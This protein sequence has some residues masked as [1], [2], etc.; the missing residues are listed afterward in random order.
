MN[1]RRWC[2]GA[3][4][5]GAS[6]AGCVGAGDAGRDVVR[7]R[8]LV[9]A[10]LPPATEARVDEAVFGAAFERGPGLTLLLHPR[11]LPRTAADTGASPVP[12][13]LAAALRE[14]GVVRGSCEPPP[15][16]RD[17]PRC[18]AAAA[19][20]VVRVSDPFRV[21]GDT[22]QVYLAA[23]RF[24]PLTGP[25]P[26]ALRLEKVYQLVEARGRWRVVGEARDPAGA[27]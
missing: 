15:D 9:V 25:K 5:V 22:L 26:E 12:A 4:L 24:A 8:G 16:E 11:R 23:A 19:G 14:R 17:T 1:T 27:P 7:G 18:D 6:L 10:A 20:Y 13:A 3:A 2:L 21:A